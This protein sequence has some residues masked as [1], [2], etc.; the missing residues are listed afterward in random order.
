MSKQLELPLVEVCP[1]INEAYQEAEYYEISFSV[2]KTKRLCC[3]QPNECNGPKEYLD[4]TEYLSRIATGD[5]SI[6]L[7]EPEENIQ[8]TLAE[9]DE[10]DREQAFDMEIERC[11][12][13]SPDE[14]DLLFNPCEMFDL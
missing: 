6:Q 1:P 13:M 7:T 4:D 14:L 10:L 5:H 8:A 3:N 2:P 12:G 11:E 9:L